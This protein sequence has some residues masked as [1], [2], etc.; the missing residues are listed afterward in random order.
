MFY[1][2]VLLSISI[3]I[4]VMWRHIAAPRDLLNADVT[5]A[6]FAAITQGAPSI[7]L[8]HAAIVLLALIAPTVAAFGYLA[9]AGLVVI[10]S[11]GDFTA[12]TPEPGSWSLYLP[13]SEHDLHHIKGRLAPLAAGAAC[14]RPLRGRPRRRPRARARGPEAFSP[15]REP[16]DVC[17]PA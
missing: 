1:G 12:P 7:G 6:E 2:L 11:R 13:A 4:T 14:G 16:S 3:V 10:R 15:S 17:P 5:D 8:P 9:I